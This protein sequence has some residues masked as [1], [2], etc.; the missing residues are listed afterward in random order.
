M[1]PKALAKSQ[2]HQTPKVKG[3][4]LGQLRLSDP[5]PHTFLVLQPL[6]INQVLKATF[7][8]S[9]SF[10]G[11]FVLG[12]GEPPLAQSWLPGVEA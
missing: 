2:P 9:P 8:I 5:V 4:S 11:P 7:P 10:T 1:T 6:S 3:K 12:R